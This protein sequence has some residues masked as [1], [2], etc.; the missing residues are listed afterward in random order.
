[1]NWGS[2]A[3]NCL[4]HEYIKYYIQIK[5]YVKTAFGLSYGIGELQWLHGFQNGSVHHTRF[6]LLEITTELPEA[7]PGLG[8]IYAAGINL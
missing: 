3:T 6:L 7:F 5:C 8:Y 2:S 4:E 1:M